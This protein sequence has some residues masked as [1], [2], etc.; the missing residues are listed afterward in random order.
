MISVDLK[1]MATDKTPTSW[2]Y[3]PSSGH[4]GRPIPIAWNEFELAELRS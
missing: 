1:D 4:T 3:P 2:A